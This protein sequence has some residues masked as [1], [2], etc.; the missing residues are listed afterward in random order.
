MVVERSRRRT[1]CGSGTVRDEPQRRRGR[2]GRAPGLQAS[3][4]RPG[5]LPSRSCGPRRAQRVAALGA[6]EPLEVARLPRFASIRHDGSARG[7]SL[8]RA[9]LPARVHPPTR[10]RPG[11]WTVAR[12]VSLPARVIAASTGARTPCGRTGAGVDASRR[13]RDP[14]VASGG[15]TET[16]RS[17]ALPIPTRVIAASAGARTPCG[18]TGA[19][20][21]TADAARA[22]RHGDRP[23]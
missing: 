18:R 5:S 22:C 4:R 19:E 9:T 23:R 15:P 3:R 7:L 2:K 10:T 12:V 20:L 6:R 17:S 16:R 8:D 21:D 11:L 1:S 13:F 14:W